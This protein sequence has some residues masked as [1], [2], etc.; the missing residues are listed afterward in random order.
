LWTFSILRFFLKLRATNLTPS[1]DRKINAVVS[2]ERRRW[3]Q[4]PINLGTP[5]FPLL[6]MHNYIIEI[7]GKINYC[8]E[9]IW[10]IS[11]ILCSWK[12]IFLKMSFCY[13]YD[14]SLFSSLLQLTSSS[15]FEAASE[16]HI[17]KHVMYIPVS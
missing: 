6:Y 3:F 17:S 12:F 16:A 10:K 15:S 11:I 1:S 5:L 7:L 9:I 2:L 13:L 4:W 8:R 14:Y